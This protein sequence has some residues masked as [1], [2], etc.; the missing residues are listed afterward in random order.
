[1]Y[2][3]SNGEIVKCFDVVIGKEGVIEYYLKKEG[4]MK[5]PLRPD[6]GLRP[7]HQQGPGRR[8]LSGLPEQRRRR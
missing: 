1:M 2:V 4:D 7:R 3:F 8:R 5:T 6:R